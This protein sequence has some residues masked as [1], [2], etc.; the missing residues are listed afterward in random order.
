MIWHLLPSHG[1]LF[2][3]PADGHWRTLMGMARKICTHIAPVDSIMDGVA[4]GTVMVETLCSA[5]DTLN[6]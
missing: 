2:I 1:R 6:G 3:I 5:T 4:K